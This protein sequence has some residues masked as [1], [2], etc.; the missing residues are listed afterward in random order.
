MS[1]MLADEI[2]V[3]K[4]TTIEIDP[5][6][7]LL[8]TLQYHTESNADTGKLDRSKSYYRWMARVMTK[9][10]ANDE[11]RKR[12][13]DTVRLERGKWPNDNSPY[14]F[15]VDN[16]STNAAIARWFET[17]MKKSKIV[18]W[19]MGQKILNGWKKAT[20]KSD[21]GFYPNA[22]YRI[23]GYKSE[24]GDIVS[25]SDKATLLKHVNQNL[26]ASFVSKSKENAEKTA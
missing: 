12:M 9:N 21:E 20:A 17:K 24:N 14:Y 26:L 11:I 16:D 2:Q 10:A 3:V 25:L 1:K 8:A 18:S 7:V 4:A 23:D 22:T 19:D 13:S 15:C 6:T 5:E